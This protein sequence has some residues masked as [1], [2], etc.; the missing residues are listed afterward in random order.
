[1]I[2]AAPTPG[3]ENPARLYTVAEIAGMWRCSTEHV[4][5][6]IRTGELPTVQLGRGD[7]NKLRVAHR[8]LERFIAANTTTAG[9]TSLSRAG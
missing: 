6:F 7:R 5:Q 9:A 8:D 1:M 4:Y 3:G 2:P